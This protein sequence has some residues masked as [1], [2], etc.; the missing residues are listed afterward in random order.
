MGLND[1]MQKKGEVTEVAL[2]SI[3]GDGSLN[4]NNNPRIS[5]ANGPNVQGG[6]LST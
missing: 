5:G 2:G 6:M 1:S 4:N 3:R